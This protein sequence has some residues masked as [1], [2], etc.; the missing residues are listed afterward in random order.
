[1]TN[2]HSLLALAAA[3]TLT[4]EIA[5]ADS[6]EAG[7]LIIPMDTTYQDYGM[8]EAYG[9]VYELLRSGVQLEWVIREGKAFGDP[10]FTTSSVDHL[11]GDPVL[12]H[13]YRGGP[14]VVRAADAP[15]A[16][17]I[18]DAWQ[19]DNP[20]TAVHEATQ[21]FDGDVTH[22]LVAAPT[23]A[24]MADG[25][26]KIARKYMAAAKIPDS[27]GDLTWPDESP[28]MLD[29]DELA[30]PTEETHNDGAL[31]DEDGTPVYCQFMS[32]HWG[33]G[34][35]EDNPEVVAE[36]RRFL[37][38]PT[39][40]FAECQA[41]NAFENLEPHGFFLTPNG[42]EIGDGPD[43]Y[44]F[45]NMD[46][47]F[48]QMDGKFASVGGSE[49]AYTLPMGDSYKSDDIVMITEAGTPIGVNDVWM[50]GL[51]DGVCP[52]SSS[53]LN[54]GKVSYLGGHEYKTDLPI[55]ENPDSL[56]TRLFLNSLFEAPCATLEGF[57][58]LELTKSGPDQTDVPEITYTLDYMNNGPLPALAVVL[59]DP[60]PSG[61][62][63]VSATDG[64][65]LMGD[66]VIWSLGNL[67]SGEGGAVEFTVTLP[68]LGVY[69]NT[70]TLDYT[71]G[72]NEFALDSNVVMTLYGDELDTD[73]TAGTATTDDPS[74]G[75]SDAGTGGDSATASDS[76]DSSDP[77]AGTGDGS[78]DT[79]G[80]TAGASGGEDAPGGCGCRSDDRSPAG[81][82]LLL[83]ALAPITRRRA[84]ARVAR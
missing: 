81:A 45:F 17:P 1:M 41:V 34:D 58:Q 6:F 43:V 49:P 19:Q 30:G 40:L 55:S 5:R 35:A 72:V 9:L 54:A 36:M 73:T 78:G 60:L 48:A 51:I 66:E 62:S 16:L 80:E 52:A 15:A 8:F 53:C 44:D 13:G 12:S 70:A 79:T 74:A 7:T 20:D 10:D 27:T 71:V 69:E 77:S 75:S 46:T 24:M 56:G 26:Q 33:V 28:D 2:R 67:G 50:T 83:L 61:A 68:A 38:H 84:R 39:H 31:F 82:L 14:F 29:P 76:S 22:T 37:Q 4:P 63:F 18:I 32:M 21:A 57:P 11:S 3:L 47:P 59:R 64:G 65:A 42:F 23:I 25:N